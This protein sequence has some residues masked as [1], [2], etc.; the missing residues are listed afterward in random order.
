MSKK[1]LLEQYRTKMT[2]EAFVKYAIACCHEQCNIDD[3]LVS[4]PKSKKEKLLCGFEW[5]RD[6]LRY[7]I[8]RPEPARDEQMSALDYFLMDPHPSLSLDYDRN[9]FFDLLT[10]KLEANEPF[11]WIEIEDKVKSD[12]DRKIIR[13]AHYW[14][15]L[16]YKQYKEEVE[17]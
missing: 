8:V 12:I 16:C 1:E 3:V 15:S 9:S 10:E 11:P 4:M 7:L 6:T 13:D 5:V 2:D 17:K 14:S